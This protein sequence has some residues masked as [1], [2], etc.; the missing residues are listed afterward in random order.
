MF[1]CVPVWSSSA[2]CG[3]LWLASVCMMCKMARVLNC[4]SVYQRYRDILERGRAAFDKLLWN[5][6]CKHA[7]CLFFFKWSS[8]SH[9][10]LNAFISP[11]VK[12]LSPS[13]LGKYYNYDSS[14]QSLSNSVMSDQCAGQWFLRASGLGDGDCQ[15]SLKNILKACFNMINI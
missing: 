15:V 6:E 9:I 7:Q 2:Y 10:Q 12:C 13:Q 4:E 14:G 1:L 8:N 11:P 5:G 3:G